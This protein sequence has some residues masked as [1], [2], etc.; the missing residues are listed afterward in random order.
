EAGLGALTLFQY[1]NGDSGITDQALL[2]ATTTMVTLTSM[3]AYVLYAKP[4]WVEPE[5]SGKKTR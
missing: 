4:Q 2:I 3:R 1:L 5:E